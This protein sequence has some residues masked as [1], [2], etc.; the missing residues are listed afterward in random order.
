M[1]HTSICRRSIVFS[2][3]VL[4]VLF[5]QAGCSDDREDLF[6][7]AAARPRGNPDGADQVAAA[8]PTPAPAAQPTPSPKPTPTAPQVSQVSAVKS[9]DTATTAVGEQADVAE[10]SVA[11]IE[12][13]P[14][15]E[16]PA[17]GDISDEESR[18]ATVQK[19]L[20]I[21]DA[22]MAYRKDHDGKLPTPS[23]V[24]DAGIACLSWRVEL[25]PYLGY[26]ELYKQFDHSTPWNFG[27]N[28][29]LLEYIPDE[30]FTHGKTRTNIVG[31]AGEFSTFLDASNGIGLDPNHIRDG[32][33][34]TL[35]LLEVNDSKAPQ[36]TEP[37]DFPATRQVAGE[38]EPY[39]FHKRGD[40][41]IGLWANGLPT[42]IQKNVEM[43]LLIDAMFIKDEQD[44]K[45]SEIHQTIA[46]AEPGEENA[47][48]DEIMPGQTD[49]ITDVDLAV[50]GDDF[51][52]DRVLIEEHDYARDAVPTV[53]QIRSAQTKL[54]SVF[55]SRIKEA[56]TNDDKSTLAGE[57]LDLAYDM[58][59]DPGG[60]YALQ[61][62]A[63]KFA[64]EAEDAALVL[65]AIDQRVS[66]FDVSALDENLKWIQEF[67]EGTSS[68]N[69]SVIDGAPLL[70]RT[71][72]VVLTAIREDEYM[73]AASI[74][75][76]AGRYTGGTR[77]D[78]VSRLMNRLRTQLGLAKGE[79]ENAKTY[80]DEYRRD[81]ENVR[82][83]AAFGRFVCFIKG[84][85]AT[86][87]KLIVDGPQNDLRE[88]ARMDLQGAG[89][90]RGQVAIGDAWWDLSRRASGPYR[91]GAQD[92]AV[93]WYEKAIE[94]LPES[95]DKIHVNNRL[96]DARD[97]TGASPIAICIQLADLLGV[98]VSQSLTSVA[99]EGARASGGRSNDDDS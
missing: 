3:C 29:E 28:K 87:L 88:V 40:S 31:V 96:Q 98:D 82:A 33:A 86:G 50:S 60:A 93:K 25:L 37:A 77:F 5:V 4:S 62:A 20:K 46:F 76:I 15:S 63:I 41:L 90:P 47:P 65:R 14:L 80:L 42:L 58:T 75:R 9:T 8:E 71:V 56:T 16:R 45:A 81:P 73:R 99:V 1:N 23:T 26:P 32:A 97:S 27:V 48:S 92:R 53:V 49:A 51:V 19:M 11:E 69:D 70:K 64:I 10:T 95:L 74:C 91:Q 13:K 35:L 66:R 94:R 68:R 59:S 57:F 72:P 83:G 61:Q 52:V 44:F 39:L 78:E 12:I 54:R 36:W 30:F 22:L 2:I 21:F 17:T 38:I 24:N 34:N 43:R 84:D 79:Y 67:G 6:M 85:W 89:T 7:K 18:R 55:S